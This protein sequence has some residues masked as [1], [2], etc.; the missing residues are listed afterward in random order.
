MR[1]LLG[2]I[3]VC[4]TVALPLVGC[5]VPPALTV[6]SLIADG[7]AVV[8]TGKTMSDHAISNLSGEDCRM[9]RIL[10]GEWI[11]HAESKVVMEAALPPAPPEPPLTVVSP[12][13]RPA[14]PIVA[15]APP[16][17]SH[18]MAAAPPAVAAAPPAQ[19]VPP[20]AAPARP[21][22]AP[23]A[24]QAKAATA[25]TQTASPPTA[26]VRP[27]TDPKSARRSA[28]AQQAALPA[29]PA[30]STPPAAR[31]PSAPPVRGEMVI[32]GGTD[33]A[34][35]EAIAGQLKAYSAKVRPVQQ[36]GVTVYEVVVG[37]N[38]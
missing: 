17:P 3:A 36:G 4:A 22:P 19:P 8:T 25:P 32:Q 15:D 10:K 26:S 16:E 7:V 9:S 21:S 37:I 33:P 2:L 1:R 24:A 13:P 18:M 12:Y 27:A 11:C 23:S 6:A 31:A 28:P 35:A 34:E 5:A 38:S 30:A 29:T 20:S 14:D